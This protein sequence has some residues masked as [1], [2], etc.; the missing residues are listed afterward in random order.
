MRYNYSIWRVP[1]QV[2]TSSC[3]TTSTWQWFKP[4]SYLLPTKLQYVSCWLL[5]AARLNCAL[6]LRLSGIINGI[7]NLMLTVPVGWTHPST[8]HCVIV[9]LPL[10]LLHL[11]YAI[12]ITPLFFFTLTLF[13]SIIKQNGPFFL[14]KKKSGIIK[15]NFCN[16]FWVTRRFLWFCYFFFMAG[17]T[18]DKFFILSFF[19]LFLRPSNW[20]FFLKK[21][22][23]CQRS[24]W[25]MY[26]TVLHKRQMD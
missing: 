4:L 15:K 12:P 11:A 20:I 13:S 6:R 8:G 25:C 22:R 14:L 2:Q 18:F 3:S 24:R 5:A 7:I 19:I 9:K 23:S 26:C 1:L 21:I 16:T 17:A 10:P